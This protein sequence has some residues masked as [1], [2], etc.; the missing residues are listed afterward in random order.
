M[1]TAIEKPVGSAQRGEPADAVRSSA[2]ASGVE[3]ATAQR[4][5]AAGEAIL[6]DVREPDEFAREHIAGAKLVP[7]SRFN[8]EEV[9]ARQGQRVVMHCRSGR[10]SLDACRLA[11]VLADRGVQIHSLIGGIEGWKAAGLPV[12]AS[13]RT[14]GLSVMRQ[15]Q[16]VIGLGTLAGSALAWFVDPMFIALPAFFGLGLAI[17]G[18]TGTCGLA[19]LL[20][21]MPWNRIGGNASQ[22]TA[23]SCSDGSCR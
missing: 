18:A 4:W 20:S 13:S 3:P 2:L 21:R 12:R 17:A 9:T 8:L 19:T 15:V 5:L 6:V 1:T 22:V 11:A 7:L 14:P 16:L 10:R 23:G